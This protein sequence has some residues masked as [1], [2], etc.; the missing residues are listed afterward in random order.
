MIDGAGWSMMG[1]QRDRMDKTTMVTESDVGSG[2]VTT[3]ITRSHTPLDFFAYGAF[4]KNWCIKTRDFPKVLN[5]S[6]ACCLY[7]GGHRA[8]ATCALIYSTA[9]SRWHRYAQ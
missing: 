4:S 5:C 2:S 6:T 9:C 7:F 1:L 8:A 3:K